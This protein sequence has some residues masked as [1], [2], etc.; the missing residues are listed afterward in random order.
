V[1]F[2]CAYVALLEH[3][4]TSPFWST[5]VRFECACPSV[6]LSE[7]ACSSALAWVHL[8]AIK[9]SEC[10]RSSALVRVHSNSCAV[11]GRERERERE[12]KRERER[13]RE[14]ERERE[15]VRVHSDSV[16]RAGPASYTR[17][18]ALPCRG[19]PGETRTDRALTRTPEAPSGAP[20]SRGRWH[21]RAPRIACTH[22]RVY[23][24]DVACMCTCTSRV[25]TR[26]SRPRVTALLGD[27][28]ARV[29]RRRVPPRRAV[30]RG[31]PR[32]SYVSCG[33]GRLGGWETRML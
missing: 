11:K 15:L 7:C 8:R 10:I 30:A 20:L 21:G 13:E 31:G 33:A 32:R 29:S 27:P 9:L 14:S 6:R 2:E 17:A 22:D 23:T 12:R 4:R 28:D 26:Q 18:A 19:P 16:T 5:L 25:H 3:T 1:R 24:R